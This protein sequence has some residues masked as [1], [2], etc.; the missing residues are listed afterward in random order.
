MFGLDA[1][2]RLEQLGAQVSAGARA[3]RRVVQAGLR[4]LGVLDQFRQGLGGDLRVDDQH[5]GHAAGQDDRREG[6]GGVVAQAAVEPLVDREDPGGGQQQGIAVGFGGGDLLGADVAAGARTVV[7]HDRLAQRGRYLVGDGARQ[8]VVGAAR[9]IRNDQRDGASRVIGGK[10]AAGAQRQ[11]HGGYPLHGVSP[12]LNC[13]G[14]TGGH[15]AGR[16]SRDQPR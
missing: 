5:I 13:F 14:M 12:L 16:A 7:D 8:D 2:L 3:H 1:G 6:L 11:R 15:A 9:A 4:G 10:R